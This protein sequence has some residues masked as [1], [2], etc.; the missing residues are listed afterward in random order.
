[1]TYTPDFNPLPHGQ[2]D[3][4]LCDPTREVNSMMVLGTVTVC[5]QLE[6]LGY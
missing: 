5:N 6:E 4:R 2:R 3:C 1:M